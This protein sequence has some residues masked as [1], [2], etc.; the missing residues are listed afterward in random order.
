MLFGK[1]FGHQL[2]LELEEIKHK[3]ALE[4]KEMKADISR[5]KK[6]WDED[7]Q[8]M[9]DKQNQEHEIKL[10]EVLTL[11]KLDSE[12]RI[13]KA[14]L[15]FESKY[16]KKCEEL[17]ATHY[18]KLAAAMS[19]LHEEGNVTT[20]FT[21]DLALKMMESMPKHKTENTTKVLTGKV[22]D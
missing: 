10:K 12:Q 22:Q 5:E 2:R 15:D 16:N 21:Q 8:R 7:R 3:H 1:L 17:N 14:E 20:K 11:T 4:I 19:K 9:V 13:K 6:Q 18:D